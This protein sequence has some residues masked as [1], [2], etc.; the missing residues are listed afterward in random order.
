MW[1]SLALNGDRKQKILYNTDTIGK[2]WGQGR[3]SYKFP[4]M[5]D[6]EANVEFTEDKIFCQLKCTS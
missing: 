1:R 5:E 6:C 4:C 3:Q 2:G